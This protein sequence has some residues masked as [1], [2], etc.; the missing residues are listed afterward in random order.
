MGGY[1][2][3]KLF[4]HL[5]ERDESGLESHKTAMSQAPGAVEPVHFY[6]KGRPRSFQ[7]SQTNIVGSVI[8]VLALILLREYAMFPAMLF[9]LWLAGNG[10]PD[11]Y[12]ALTDS[13]VLVYATSGRQDTPNVILDRAPLKTQQTPESFGCTVGSQSITL[14]APAKKRFHQALQ[15]TVKPNQL[16]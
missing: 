11:R 4:K 5:S 13:E 10:K 9:A 2:T 12:V 14:E 6:V 7:W 8:T 3:Y 15:A 1:G 16:S